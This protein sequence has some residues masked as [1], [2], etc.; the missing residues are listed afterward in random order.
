LTRAKERAHSAIWPR[1]LRSHEVRRNPPQL[2]KPNGFPGKSNFFRAVNHSF[3]RGRCPFAH[4]SRCSCYHRV[5][6]RWGSV[7]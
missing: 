2:A 6:S 1:S 5:I 7:A 4:P 3:A